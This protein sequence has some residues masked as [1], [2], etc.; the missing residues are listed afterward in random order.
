MKVPASI[1]VV[2]AWLMLMSVSTM[3]L[4]NATVSMG[5]LVDIELS[6]VLDADDLWDEEDSLEHEVSIS[7]L[8]TLLLV[9][10]AS[11]FNSTSLRHTQNVVRDIFVPPPEQKSLLFFI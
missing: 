8:C 1:S 7:P 4:T 5:K 10:G 9:H 3:L 2:L 11:S 6:E